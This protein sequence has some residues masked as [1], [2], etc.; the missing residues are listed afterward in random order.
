MNIDDSNDECN[1]E[2]VTGDTVNYD[3]LDL[4]NISPE[5][6]VAET[7]HEFEKIWA[8]RRRIYSILFPNITGFEND[9]YD[10]S[11]A[12]LFTEDATGNITST[13]RLAFDGPQGLPEESLVHFLIKEHRNRGLKLAEYGRLIIE[14]DPRKGLIKNYY[15]SVY[16]I[17]VDNGVDSI[18]V[19]S[20][21]K[22]LGFYQNMIGATVLGDVN[23]TF[24]GKQRYVC[25]EWKIYE[26]KTRFL[27]WSGVSI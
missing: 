26:T 6:Q 24:G 20:K 3:R 17:A 16:T 14:D 21:R 9:L 23:E 1:G 4:T 8:F 25:L 10:R 7:R 2:S 11:A 27:K 12:V 5:L 13:G 18:I 15:K 22:D 19:V